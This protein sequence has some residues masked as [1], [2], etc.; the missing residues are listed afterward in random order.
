[1]NDSNQKPRYDPKY[2][3]FRVATYVLFS[4]LIA[5]VVVGLTWSI[6][7]YLLGQTP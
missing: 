7:T 3:T 6:I 1:M 4:G 2:K 5:Y